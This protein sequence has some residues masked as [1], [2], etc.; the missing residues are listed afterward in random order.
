MGCQADPSGIFSPIG[1]RASSRRCGGRD[2]GERPCGSSWVMRKLIPFKY[3]AIAFGLGLASALGFAPLNWW[4]V[5]LLCM[6]G[7]MALL[8]DAPRARDVAWRGWCFGVGH[9]T[10]GNNWIATAFTFQDA[11]PHWLGGIAVFLLALY[12]AIFP[13][14]AGLGAWALN[15]LPRLA[16]ARRNRIERDQ[17]LSKLKGLIP[18]GMEP[19]AATAP[20]AAP[21]PF[22]FIPLF[23]G[24]WIA[25]EYLRSIAFTGFAWN[26]LG[27]VMVAPGTA[28]PAWIG[29]TRLVGTYGLSGWVVLLSGIWLLAVLP[30]TK[31]QR[32]QR[33]GVALL[34]A[35]LAQIL[36]AW[37]LRPPPPRAGPRILVV[38]PN[39][40]QNEKWDPKLQ[41]ANFRRLSELSGKP[42]PQPRL[43]LW[44]E[45]ATA[46]FLELDP[47]ARARIAGLLGPR[48]KVLLGGDALIFDKAGELAGAHNS[49]FALDAR[50]DI[51]GRYD[52][53]H[54][55][56][57]GEY[58]PARTI[59]SAIGLSR[60]VPG[61]VDFWSGPGPATMTVPGFG[62]A[63]IQICYE[64]IFS[65]QV[66][67]A[68]NRPDFLFNPSNDAWFGRW[69]PPQ[70]LAQA[71][72][73]AVEEGLPVIRSTPTGISAVVDADGRLLHSL[74]WHQAGAI[75]AVLPPP[76]PA[77][78]FARFGNLLPLLF[79][80]LLVAGGIAIAF[81]RR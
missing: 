73:R 41:L 15:R 55:V 81:K 12:L 19:Q 77:T 54:L 48:D 29:L 28:E 70:H 71:R 34:V 4:F 67:D 50:G 22:A 13:M 32:W 42:G 62:K 26:P 7:L 31:R 74:P 45:A 72:L 51:L 1:E 14:L 10:F 17:R 75:D 64:I 79:A 20:V 3:P 37:L 65:G 68:R 6:A 63:G 58:L 61:D 2:M 76:R 5:T 46:D 25:A 30:G 69:G 49:L 27:A 36:S 53:A 44:P 9:F 39:I 80:A 21:S 47:P 66:V 11:M 38:Q 35:M 60:L 16:Q 78:P 18:A 52:K 57:Y 33:V 43:I 8:L 40:N 24:C 23:A 59:L 56:P